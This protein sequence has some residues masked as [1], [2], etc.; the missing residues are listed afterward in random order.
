MAKHRPHVVKALGALR[1]KIVLNQGAHATGRAFRTQR[2]ILAVK[3]VFKGIHFLLNDVGYFAD[4]A[5][6][7]RRR[8]DDGHTDRPVAVALQPGTGRFLEQFPQ[9]RFAGQD[10]VHPANG[11]DSFAHELAY[12]VA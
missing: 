5:P 3:R 8:L 1:R 2:Q 4:S 6:K 7:Q 12:E 11:L 10:V 9:F